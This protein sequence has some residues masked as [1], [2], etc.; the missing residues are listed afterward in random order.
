MISMNPRNPCKEGEEESN[1][2]RLRNGR[3]KI[4]VILFQGFAAQPPTLLTSPQYDTQM[5]SLSHT[6]DI[7]KVGYLDI[8]NV[9]IAT[10]LDVCS[11]MQ[12]AILTV[13]NG[14]KI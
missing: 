3:G 14:F 1:N 6:I 5:K 4:P 2:L 7:N 8:Q 11:W 9:G 10:Q 12:L 13:F